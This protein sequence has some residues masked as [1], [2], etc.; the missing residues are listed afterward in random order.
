MT[1]IKISYLYKNLKINYF[2][3]LKKHLL[4]INYSK[5]IILKKKK[6]NI[7]IKKKELKK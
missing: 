7:I 2:N 4:I 1:I 3:L 6:Y 5:N